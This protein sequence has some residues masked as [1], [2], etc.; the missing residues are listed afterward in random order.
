MRW[1]LGLREITHECLEQHLYSAHAQSVLF[2]PAN[3]LTTKTLRLKNARWLI[4]KSGHQEENDWGWGEFC[5]SE[6]AH[7]YF[8]GVAFK[9]SLQSLH[10]S[11]WPPLS[12][13]SSK[14]QRMQTPG[15]LS[16]HLSVGCLEGTLY[17]NSVVHRVP[18]SVT[19]SLP[20]P[21]GH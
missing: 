4:Y 14:E 10:S 21:P 19:Q 9:T 13:R 16:H 17:S 6:L 18:F 11:H 12:P 5:D 2:I 20:D 15:K 8:K 3:Y 7:Y 1:P